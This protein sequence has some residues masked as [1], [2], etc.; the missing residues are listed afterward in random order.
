[1]TSHQTPAPDDAVRSRAGTYAGVVAVEVLVIV[2]LWW[3]SRC[4]SA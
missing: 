2:A 3:F 4:F 1:V